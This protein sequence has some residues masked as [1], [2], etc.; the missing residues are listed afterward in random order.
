MPIG[1]SEKAVSL[2]SSGID[3]PVSS[4][5]LIKRGVN[6]S[7][8]HFHSTPATSRQSIR[9]VERIVDKLANYSLNA[10]LAFI[11]KIL[12]KSVIIHGNFRVLFLLQ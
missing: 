2:L 12:T 6:V 11:L 3:S 8:V 10:N 4:F 5:E 7:Y 1:V 9:L